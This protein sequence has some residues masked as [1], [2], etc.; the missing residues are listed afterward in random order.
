[1]PTASHWG[2]TPQQSIEAE[3]ARR[4]VSAVVAGCVR[5][6]GGDDVDAGLLTALGGPAAARHLHGARDDRYW[7]RVW[8]VRGLLWA[9]EDNA[10]AAVRTALTDES[11]RVREL[12]A[13]VAAKRLIGDALPVLAQLGSDPVA[14]V[15]VAADRAVRVLTRARA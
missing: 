4:G 12:A 11:W 7:L 9:W 2:M 3:C 1:M 8:G 15:R 10:T 14:R 5:L 6:I 13:K